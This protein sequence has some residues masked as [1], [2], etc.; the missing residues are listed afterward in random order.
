MYIRFARLCMR[1]AT[2]FVDTNR[3]LREW[4]GNRYVAGCR[5]LVRSGICGWLRGHACPCVSSSRFIGVSQGASHSPG[6]FDRRMVGML[7]GHRVWRGSVGLCEGRL[8]DLAR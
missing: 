6:F 2:V 8:S 3:T 7:P 5:Q 4:P 1:Q